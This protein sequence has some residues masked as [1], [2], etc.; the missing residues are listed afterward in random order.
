[1]QRKRNHIKR[2]V[3]GIP[4]FAV[5]QWFS[6]PFD[7]QRFHS[8]LTNLYAKMKSLSRSWQNSTWKQLLRGKLFAFTIRTVAFFTCNIL[9]KRWCIV[10]KKIFCVYSKDALPCISWARV[11]AVKSLVHY[12]I[13]KLH[14]FF[15]FN[16]LVLRAFFIVL[17][18]TINLQTKCRLSHASKAS[19]WTNM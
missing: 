4:K 7:Y 19:W 1:M 6:K 2:N 8:S 13:H 5:K 3:S 10:S 17:E 18:Q 11:Y 14:N 15:H 16:G 12:Y 9:I